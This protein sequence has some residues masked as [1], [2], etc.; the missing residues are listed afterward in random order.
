M[1]TLNGNDLKVFGSKKTK[2]HKQSENMLREEEF[3]LLF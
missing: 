2:E 3:V 1:R